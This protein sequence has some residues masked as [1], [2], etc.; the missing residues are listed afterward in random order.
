ME[1]IEEAWNHFCDGD[2]NFQDTQTQPLVEVQAPKCSEL[3]ISTKTKISYLNMP[4]NLYDTFWKIPVILY[5]LP[6]EGIIKKQMKFNSLS[7]KEL[8][9]LK[10][11]ISDEKISSENHI[12][13]YII[14]QVDAQSNRNSFKDVRKISIGLSKKDITSY[15]CKKKSAFYN[16]FVV[17][18]RLKYNNTFKE[19]SVKVF[20]TGKLQ[21]PGIQTDDTL[22][23]ILDLLISIL[24][25]ICNNSTPI[26]YLKEKHQTVLI[27]S[28]FNCGYYINREKLYDIL[29]YN[30]NINSAYDPCSYPGIQCEF[31]YI[32]DSDLPQNGKQ[33][34]CTS[35]IDVIK[36]SFMIFRTGSVLIVGKCSENI[37]KSIYEFIKNLLEIEFHKIFSESYSANNKDNLID[38]KRKVRKKTIVMDKPV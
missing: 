28:N 9:E 25:P 37:L 35:D 33:P 27:N 16:C 22:D 29:K 10:Q 21:I 30:Y 3:Y 19:H 24:N 1:D 2:Y 23:K 7:C 32:V 5:H 34:N 12:D 4:I 13:E 6:K 20:N 8:T 18:L 11:R 31:F 15:K 14:Q 17:I 26:T 38:S 36:V